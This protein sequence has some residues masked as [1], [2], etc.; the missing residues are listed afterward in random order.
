[1]HI[2]MTYVLFVMNFV[3]LALEEKKMNVYL[4]SINNIEKWIQQI[5]YVE[6]VILKMEK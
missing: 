2:K 1:M 6:K 3:K 5:A 4:V